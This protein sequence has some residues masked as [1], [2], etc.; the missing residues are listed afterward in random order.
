M[1][2]NKIYTAI[3]SRGTGKTP[4]ITG[5][6]LLPGLEETYKYFN[7]GL[8]GLYL[9]KGMSTLVID[10]IDHVRYREKF[11][12]LHPDSYRKT[13]TA[14]PGFYRTLSPVHFM[15]PLKQRMAVEKLVWN[16]LIVWEDYHKHIHNPLTDMESILVGNSKQQNIDMFFATWDWGFLYPDLA[17]F[18][19]YY[20]VFPSASSPE[21][22]KQY[23]KGC[24]DKVC[25]A[26]EKVMLSSRTDKKIPYLIVD[27]GI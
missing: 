25:T 10:E 27:S 23:L 6:D 12:L 1:S 11:P 22:R 9:R 19:N 8:A 14:K 24:Y 17:R 20:V 4:F 5:G 7:P 2:A 18:T 13:L 15:E 26:W 16:T 21:N 3:G